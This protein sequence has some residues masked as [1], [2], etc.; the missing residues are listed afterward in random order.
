MHFL[1]YRRLMVIAPIVPMF[2]ACW[3]CSDTPIDHP[4]S[5][6]PPAATQISPL[7]PL[8]SAQITP[9]IDKMRVGETF[10]F[11][12]QLQFGEG[13]VSPSAKLPIWSSRP[14]RHGD[15]S[16]WQGDAV[17]EGNATIEV[18]THG[19]KLAATFR[20]STK[21]RYWRL[22]SR[23]HPRQSLTPPFRDSPPATEP[24]VA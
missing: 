23:R 15:R 22:R 2:I 7:A 17:G 16:D 4:T 6:T 14:R 20:C 24:V 5:P 21:S 12:T 9:A 19:Y 10:T 18:G 1:G 8:L 11:S 13:G 3:G